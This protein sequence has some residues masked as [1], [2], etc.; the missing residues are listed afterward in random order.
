MSM[1]DYM[2]QKV[3]EPL[4]MADSA[5]GW[6]PETVAAM[7]TPYSDFGG[8]TPDFRSPEIAAGGLNMTIA[9]FGRLVAAHAAGGAEPR[10]RGVLRP[11]TVELMGTPTVGTEN[12]PWGLGLQLGIVS[13]GGRPLVGHDGG[14]PGWG[15]NYRIDPVT[16]DGIAVV[17]NRSWGTQVTGP[18]MCEWSKRTAATPETGPCFRDRSA[19]VLHTIIVDGLD[20]GKTR[21]EA[22]KTDPRPISDPQMIRIGRQLVLNDRARDA[23]VVLGWNLAD[24][25]QSTAAHEALADA[26][27]AAGDR[28]QAIRLMEE[29][30]RLAPGEARISGKLE[31]LRNPPPAPATTS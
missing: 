13:P 6:S 10:G 19:I 29:A 24:N 1:I 20:A 8:P 7:G 12:T 21:Y 30:L 4:G 16:G 26:H 23:V 28:D 25:P 31:R 5:Y 14:N 11:E 15:A 3:L 18:I 27:E 2:D 22:F 9:D 17:I